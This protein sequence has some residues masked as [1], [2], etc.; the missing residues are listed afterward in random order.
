MKMHDHPEMQVMTYILA[1]NMMARTL[2]HKKK[3]LYEEK[4]REI[5]NK[6][7]L[8]IDGMEENF[9]EFV[10]GDSGCTFMD[11]LFPDYDDDSREFKMYDTIK[12]PS[13][14][15]KLV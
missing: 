10:G 5:G 3:N 15:Y 12:H 9:H 8:T 4:L 11:I 6:D 14:F 13:G 2:T 7:I 1:G